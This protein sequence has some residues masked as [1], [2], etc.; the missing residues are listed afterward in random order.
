MRA[1]NASRVRRAAQWLVRQHLER[2]PSRPMPAA[3]APRDVAEAY[4]VQDDFVMLKARYCG[5]VAG[6]KIALTT[7]RMRA[8]VGLDTPIAGQ[9]HARQIVR[10]PGLVRAAEYVRLIVEFEIAMQIARDLVPDGTPY[11]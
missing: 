5:Q 3:L 6:H 2:I 8:L 1:A 11:T 7:P 4:A 10:G 9:L